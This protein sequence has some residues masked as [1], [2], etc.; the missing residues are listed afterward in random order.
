[1]KLSAN[2][3]EADIEFALESGVDYIVLDGRG[4]GTGAAPEMFRDHISVPTIPALDRARRFLDNAGA[5]GQVTLIITGGLR[6]PIDFVKAMALGA[7]GVALS[8]SAMQAIGCVGARMCNSNNCPAGI[9]TQKPELRARLDIDTS[10]Q[11]LATFFDASVE[12]MSVMAR[13]CGHDHLSKL[14]QNDL[15][16]WDD[17]MARLSGIRFSGLVD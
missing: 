3:I 15:A 12:L 17:K 14:T 1:M 10:A 4:G 6:V 11:Q 9:A 8:N 5:S 16:T 2:H 7:D 13:A